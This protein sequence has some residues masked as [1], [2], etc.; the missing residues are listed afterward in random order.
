MCLR[1]MFSVLIEEYYLTFDSFYSSFTRSSFLKVQVFKGSGFSRSMFFKVRVFQGRGFSGSM[2]F[3][4]LVFKDP[5]FSG[6]GS[7][8]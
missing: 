8:V 3:R 7:R 1:S 2:F 5:Q 4:V 6:F